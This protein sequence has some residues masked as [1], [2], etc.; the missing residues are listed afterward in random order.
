M[1]SLIQLIRVG[2]EPFQ[3]KSNDVQEKDYENVLTMMK[4]PVT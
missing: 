3:T 2:E 1:N 4:N